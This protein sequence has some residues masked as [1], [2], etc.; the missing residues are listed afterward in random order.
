MHG[1][2][3]L[4]RSQK[5]MSFTGEDRSGA[6]PF[7]K[8][9]DDEDEEYSDDFEDAGVS[10]SDQDVHDDG[11]G[12]RVAGGMDHEFDRVQTFDEAAAADAAS[13]ALAAPLQATAAELR[14][15]MDRQLTAQMEQSKEELS[16]LCAGECDCGRKR[17]TNF[18]VLRLKPENGYL[19]LHN[20]RVA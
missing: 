8:F 17:V 3:V 6:S 13:A 14:K 4:T 1:H 16:Q 15:T 2:G 19:F 11:G 9:D 18:L 20:F 12:N 5:K 10:E 7:D